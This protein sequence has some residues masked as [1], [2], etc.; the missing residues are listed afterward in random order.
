MKNFYEKPI[1]EL[2]MFVSSN[3]VITASGD[4]FTN[5]PWGDLEY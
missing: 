2:I 4:G 1:L 3:D 5:D